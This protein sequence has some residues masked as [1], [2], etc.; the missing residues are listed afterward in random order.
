M[1]P[2]TPQVGYESFQFRMKQAKINHTS[3]LEEELPLTQSVS[4]VILY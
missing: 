3:E 2:T 4:K 1:T